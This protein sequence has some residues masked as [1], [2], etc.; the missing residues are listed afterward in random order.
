LDNQGLIC[1][2]QGDYETA[3]DKYQ[4]ALQVVVDQQTRHAIQLHVADMKLAVEEPQQALVLYQELLHEFQEDTSNNSTTDSM[5]MQGVLWHNIASIHVQMGQL[6]VAEQGF[7][8]ALRLKEES[9]GRDDHPELAKTW[10]ALGA[11]YYGVL[12]EKEQALECFRHV[13][14]ITRSHSSHDDPRTDPDVLAAIQTISDI[15]QSI[16]RERQGTN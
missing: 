8:E 15:Q 2:L 16:D 1:R 10:N 12:N 5:G 14:W 4:Q 13:L 11:L 3:L 7:R 6:D 9:A